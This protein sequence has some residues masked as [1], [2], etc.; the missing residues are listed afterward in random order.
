MLIVL[1]EIMF[2]SSINALEIEIVSIMA[3]LTGK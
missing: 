2:K 1:K 3:S